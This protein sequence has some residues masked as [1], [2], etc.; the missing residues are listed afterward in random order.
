MFT[1]QMSTA[2]KE[3]FEI[4]L[5]TISF[6]NYVA[7]INSKKHDFCGFVVDEVAVTMSSVFKMSGYQTSDDEDEVVYLNKKILS[8]VIK[9]AN[10]N[11]L[12]EIKDHNIHITIDDVKLHFV[13]T[14]VANDETAEYDLILSHYNEIGDGYVINNDVKKLKTDLDRFTYFTNSNFGGSYPIFEIKDGKLTGGKNSAYS[15]IE[16]VFPI[17][18]NVVL[19]IVSFKRLQSVCNMDGEVKLGSNENIVFISN[20]R[21]SYIVDITDHPQSNP[22]VEKIISQQD[23]EASFVMSGAERDKTVDILKRLSI[24]L[25]TKN[26]KTVEMSVRNNN[27]N[28][29][30][31][32]ISN[33]SSNKSIELNVTK[34]DID[35][36]I[37]FE[38]SPFM[39]AIEN[40]E[41]TNDSNIVVSVRE[42]VLEIQFENVK[43]YISIF[44]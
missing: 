19:P 6:S 17:G 36:V 42:S 24:V 44:I 11:V 40:F 39:K 41:K 9:N 15:V 23:V 14:E 7:I 38:I 33:L 43:Y 1:I 31:T 5:K 16:D 32:D 3:E 20:G 29:S 27:V 2:S 28:F 35:H 30:V 21:L 26:E 13:A 22:D 12:F 25:L 10:G 18:L 34:N 8:N 4:F 37:S